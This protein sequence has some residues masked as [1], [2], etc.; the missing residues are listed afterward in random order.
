MKLDL[1]GLLVF[2]L[3]LFLAALKLYHDARPLCS[4]PRGCAR[5]ADVAA[6]HGF[7]RGVA[8]SLRCRAILNDLDLN[9]FVHR[10]FIKRLCCIQK[11][12]ADALRRQHAGIV[13][14]KHLVT[15]T[16]Y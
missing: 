14:S 3:N 2:R 12:R 1:C 6:L 11:T 7:E 16:R 4:L 9:I 13:L 5:K 15:I 10:K 8:H